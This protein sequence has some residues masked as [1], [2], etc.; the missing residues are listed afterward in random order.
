MGQ[1]TE[2]VTLEQRLR[3]PALGG[4]LLIA[5]LLPLLVFQFSYNNAMQSLNNTGVQRIN[6]YLNQ[7]R[8]SFGLKQQYVINLL[9]SDNDIRQFAHTPQQSQQ[10]Q[11]NQ[12]KQ[13]QQQL[14]EQSPKESSTCTDCTGIGQRR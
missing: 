12:Q 8:D 4:V 14:P 11:Q 2:A 3:L 13:Q 5:S 7:V 6:L 10:Q 9:T 1:S